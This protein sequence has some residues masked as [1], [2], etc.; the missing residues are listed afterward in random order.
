MKIDCLRIENFGAIKNFYMKFGGKLNVICSEYWVDIL[1]VL[2]LVAG[3]KVIGFNF[4]RYVFNTYTRIYAAISGNFGKASI[5]LFYD[6]SEPHGCGRRIILNGK[7]AAEEDLINA[8][9]ATFERE[10]CSVC[11]NEND[12]RRYVPFSEYDFSK[13]I[14]N[15]VLSG[16]NK[17]SRNERV[18][19]TNIFKL[20][21]FKDRLHEFISSFSPVSINSSND[22]WL[23][24]KKDGTFFP[25]CRGKDRDDLSMSERTIFNYLCFLEV[26]RFWGQVAGKL[27]FRES[28]PLYI[29]DFICFIDE[30]VNI[31]PLIDRMLSLGRQVFLFSDIKDTAE[32]LI[33][34][35]DIKVC[36]SGDHETY[37]SR[38]RRRS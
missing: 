26:N 30:A 31:K 10:E 13:K 2:G 20:K 12:Y 1:A 7:K 19:W 28:F 15:Y 6:E 23:S 25:L 29:C 22:I 36:M 35:D 24:I 14:N 38:Y 32:R 37:F 11:I 18:V 3:S 16:E 17:L 9:G 4:T 5:D 27:N 34:T 8:I 33:N 21:E